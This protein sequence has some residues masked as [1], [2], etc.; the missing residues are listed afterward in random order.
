MAR[1]KDLAAATHTIACSKEFRSEIN[2]KYTPEKEC[3]S[4]MLIREPL[5]QAPFLMT[6]LG[7]D[8]ESRLYAVMDVHHVKDKDGI[9]GLSGRVCNYRIDIPESKEKEIHEEIK[10]AILY[11]SIAGGRNLLAAAR[12]LKEK[13]PNIEKFVFVS[14]YSTLEGST[15]VVKECK[16]IGVKPVFFCMHELLT[17]SPINEY[18]CYYPEWNINKKDEELMKSFYGKDFRKMQMG[19]DWTANSLGKEQSLDVYMSQ[20]ED[21]GIDSKEFVA[22]YI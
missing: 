17:A 14:V 5:I 7:T 19:G 11:D 3:I 18:D 22:K 8:H 4:A 9:K 1:G 13:F 2:T 12:D 21:F 20:L 16:K 10:V 6:Y 15:R